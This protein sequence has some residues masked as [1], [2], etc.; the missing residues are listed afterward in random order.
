MTGPLGPKPDTGAVVEP[1][2][3]PL[4]LFPGDLE[5]LPP[6]DAL[7]TLGVHMPA[8]GTQ[9]RRDPA[10]A[11]TTITA[12]QPDDIPGQGSLIRT[13]TRRPALGRAVL[14]DHQTGTP[15]R[16]LELAPQVIDTAPATGGAQ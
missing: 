2:T 5:P 1:Q 11:V 16:H 3:A 6:P 13:A 4:R 7:D 10:I 12:G 15:F 14:A 9:Q 8:F